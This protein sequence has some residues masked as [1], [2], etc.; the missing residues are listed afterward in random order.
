VQKL[1]VFGLDLKLP[2]RSHRPS[3]PLW[4]SGVVMALLPDIE[5]ELAPYE[6]RP[7]WG[8]LFAF[9]DDDLARRLARLPDF[10]E[11]RTTYDPR[12]SSP[13]PSSIG[14]PDTQGLQEPAD[15]AGS[16]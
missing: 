9:N 4:S 15:A 13:M 5:A 3:A 8:K 6:P 2:L 16:L 12:A 7:H 1:L 11:L 10:L 14:T